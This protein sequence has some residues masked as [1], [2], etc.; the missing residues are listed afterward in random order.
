MRTIIWIVMFSKSK[1]IEQNCCLVRVASGNV[2]VTPFQ[3]VRQGKGL[4]CES[5]WV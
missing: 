1:F 5:E 2:R 4:C 3:D